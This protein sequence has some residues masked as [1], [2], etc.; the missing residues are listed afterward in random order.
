MKMTASAKLKFNYH[1]YGSTLGSLK[2]NWREGSNV[3][4][5]WEKSSPSKDAWIPAAISLAQ[6]AGKTGT[7][8]F[9]GVRGRSWSGD[10]AIDDV[11]LDN[12]EDDSG[13]GEIAGGLLESLEDT[14]EEEN[15]SDESEAQ[16]DDEEE[17]RKE[18]EAAHAQVESSLLEEGADVEEEEEEVEGTFLNEDELALPDLTQD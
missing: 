15:P 11:G 8:E 12:G 3:Q 10:I 6:F 17:E 9:E 2:V 16:L 4:K 18:A 1:L 7:V 14:Q 5:L 13:A